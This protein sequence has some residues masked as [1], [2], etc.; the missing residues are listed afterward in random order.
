MMGFKSFF[1]FLF[2]FPLEAFATCFAFWIA[3]C[4]MCE[5]FMIWAG[6][7]VLCCAGA[8]WWAAGLA[9]RAESVSAAGAWELLV[10]LV[11]LVLLLL[12]QLL[13]RLSLLALCECMSGCLVVT[14][15][16]ILSCHGRLDAL[17]TARGLMDRPG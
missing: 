4:L 12:L 17:K 8:V 3:A 16:G 9:G 14:E 13:Q 2:A 5:P 15:K 1:R 10:L 11:L 7:L 6:W